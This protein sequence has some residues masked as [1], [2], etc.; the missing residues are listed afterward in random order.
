MSFEQALDALNH[1]PDCPETR[2]LAIDI[3]LDLRNV[4]L[5]LN[6]FGA[7]FDHL[8]QAEQIAISLNDRYRL[9]WV[10]AKLTACYCND[11]RPSEAEA[12]GLRAMAIADESAD[13][14]LQVVAHFFLGLAYV[15][16]CRW[17]ESIPLLTWNA[18]RLTG[19][20]ASEWFGE[21]ARPAVVSR[22]Y[23]LRALAE[24]GQ[25]DDGVAQG[26]EAVR[27]SEPTDMSLS[28]ASAL[29]GLGFVHLRRGDLPEAIAALEQSQRLCVERQF[30][31]ILY[32]VQA[33]LGYAYALAGRDAEALPLLEASAVVDRG[34]HPAL[35]IAM[36][37]EAHLLAGRVDQAQHCVDRALALA[38]AGE[39]HGSRAWTLR[40]AAEV[41]LAHGPEHADHAEAHYRAAF[42][43]AEEAEM[44]PLQA[45][46]HLGLGKLY[47]T[48]RRP[49]H[50]RTELS[51]AVTM[52]RDLGMAFW[53]PEAEAALAQAVTPPSDER[54]R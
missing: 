24:V 40:L 23:L 31:I 53:L 38:A 30:H 36:L 29:E 35:R 51:M 22:S 2:Q 19:A 45:H 42:A 9:G 5:P 44:R 37:G 20:L 6:E 16:A 46:C 41:A 47:R 48:L 21:P 52:L 1:L 43:I 32:A 25:F 28:D 14:P 3:R 4:L 12:A 7:M 13:L 11:S 10:S 18:E 15:Y 49:E 34:L 39:E 26:E 50:A 8:L 54:A 33:Y 27:L 17:R